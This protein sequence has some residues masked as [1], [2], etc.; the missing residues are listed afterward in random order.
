MAV[1][2]TGYFEERF[3]RS[4]NPN[5]VRRAGNHHRT[6]STYLNSLVRSGFMLELVEEPMASP[7]LAQQQPLYEEVPIFFAARAR[8]G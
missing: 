6:L 3:W 4:S 1:Q 2:V 7:L 5:G 8:V